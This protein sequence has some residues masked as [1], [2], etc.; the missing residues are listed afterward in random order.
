MPQ[1]LAQVQA[2]LLGVGLLQIALAL[3]ALVAMAQVVATHA[4][5]M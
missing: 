4:T 3:L 2:V 5:E 1:V